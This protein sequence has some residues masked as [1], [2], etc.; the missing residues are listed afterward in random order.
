MDSLQISCVVESIETEII[1]QEEVAQ[2]QVDS[3]N[4]MPHHLSNVVSNYQETVTSVPLQDPH[5][6]HSATESLQAV[7][8]KIA[9]S[10]PTTPST[11]HLTSS[12]RLID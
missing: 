3:Y 12:D 2:M 8:D 4:S 11:C 1:S 9:S 5:I 7:S 6:Y 10:S